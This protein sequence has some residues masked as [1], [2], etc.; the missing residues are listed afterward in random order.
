MSAGR[1]HRYAVTLDW[2]GNLG[3]GT[4]GYRSYERAHR[5]SATGKPPIEGSSDP[6]F[7]GDAKR[8]NPEELLVASL[9]ACHQLWYLHLASEAGIVVTAYRDEAVGEMVE[10]ADGAGRFTGVTLHP[11]V[12]LA[13]GGDTALAASLHSRAHELC[14]IARSVAFPVR[15]EPVSP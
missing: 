10:D 4:D 7:R 8:W 11:E 2:T 13:P 1:A 14:F 9:S 6:A 15:C 3:T 5:L 12:T